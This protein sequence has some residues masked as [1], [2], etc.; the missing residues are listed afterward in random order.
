MIDKKDYLDELRKIIIM[1]KRIFKEIMPLMNSLENINAKEERK[2]INLQ[3]KSL[4]NSLKETNNN[5]SKTLMKISLAKPLH[6]KLKTPLHIEKNLKVSKEE[7]ESFIYPIFEKPLKKIKFSELEKK[8]LKRMK[9]KKTKVVKKK[10][11][12][13]SKYVQI[14]NKIFFNISKSLSEKQMFLTLKRDLVKSNLQ[15]ILPSYVSLILFT[16]LLS[17]LV[18]GFI[19]L[20]FLFF[21]FGAKFPIITVVTED[22]G[23]RFLKVFWILF[24]VPVVTFLFAYFYPSMEKK[25]LGTKINQELP[26]ATIHMASISNSLIDQSKMFDIIVSTKE[27]PNL[28]KEFIK[29]IN[30]INIYGYNLVS[31]LRNRAFNSPSSKLADLFNGLAI[32]ITSGGSLPEFFDRRAQTLLLE[33][34][35]EKEKYTRTA[36]TFMDIYISVVIAAP[37][38]L[39]LLLI[40]MKVSGLGVSLSMSMITLIMILGVSL[41][42]VVFLTFLR[43]KQPSEF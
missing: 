33:H 4:K 24:V 11:R 9:K 7:L 31:A 41:I 14:S 6:T 29:L 43:L 34:R 19:F 36:E 28:E 42:N 20:F 5:L 18:G 40:M 26:F 25:S 37:M 30:E 2:M 1:E 38:I 8:S 21:N 23:K 32:T 22:L 12:K 10:T 3:I 17:L 13:P 15:F 27:Y 16:T 39:M 35:L